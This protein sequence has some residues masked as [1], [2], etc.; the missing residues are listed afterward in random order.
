VICHVLI[1]KR[2]NTFSFNAE[3]GQI[4]TIALGGYSTGGWTDTLD[5]Y[6]LTV[7][8]VPIPGAV[9]LFGGT[10]VALFY[11]TRALLSRCQQGFKS[12]STLWKNTLFA[13]GLLQ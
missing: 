6:K 8:Q 7:S 11:S 1:K 9:W 4:Y 2:C 12:L 5:G 3:A 10:L 13:W